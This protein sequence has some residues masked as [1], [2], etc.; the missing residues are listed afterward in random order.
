MKI[1]GINLGDY[2]R[3]ASLHIFVLLAWSIA[4]FAF[5]FYNP[6][7]SFAMGLVAP[8]PMIVLFGHL[9]GK[10]SRLGQAGFAGGLVGFITGLAAGLLMASEAVWQLYVPFVGSRILSIASYAAFIAVTRAIFGWLFA[11]IGFALFRGKFK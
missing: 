5:S 4:G 3:K 11:L 1:D 6:A 7:I 9:G 8:I 2:F 10:F